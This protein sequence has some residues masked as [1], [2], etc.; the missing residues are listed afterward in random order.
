MAENVRSEKIRPFAWNKAKEVAA[1]LLAED[2]LTDAEIAT[3]VNVSARQLGRWKEHPEFAARISIFLQ[4][5]G[6]ASLRHAI[7]RRARRVRALDER[8]QALLKV[9]TERAADPTMQNIPG[10]KTGLLVRR[11][12]S[13]RDESGFRVVQEVEVD[14]GLLRE[15]REHE[16]QAAQ[17][18][19]QW[20]EKLDQ[21]HSGKIDLNLTLEQALEADRELE[22]WRQ[23][24]ETSDNEGRVS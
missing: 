2:E 14:V 13:L 5:M 16:K 21:G 6:S 7:A 3:Q 20:V 4:E 15:L 8:W 24:R 18:L 23:S 10:A 9:Q 11:Y 1:R 12:K 22:E 17:E 19:G